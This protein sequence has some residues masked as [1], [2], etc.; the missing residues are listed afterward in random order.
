[1]LNAADI[2][3]NAHDEASLS[4]N[5][6]NICNH[7]YGFS[8]APLALMNAEFVIINAFVG[9]IRYG[10][11]AVGVEVDDV[12]WDTDGAKVRYTLPSG[13]VYSTHDDSTRLYPIEGPGI[14]NGRGALDMA[15]ILQARGLLTEDRKIILAQLHAAQTNG[16]WRSRA[17]APRQMGKKARTEWLAY[18][19]THLL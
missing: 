17:A 2:P 13:R 1:M 12:S 8:F 11:P 6:K 9:A 7:Q 5:F 16:D 4:E 3:S 19:D 18:F 14:T 10:R 15:P